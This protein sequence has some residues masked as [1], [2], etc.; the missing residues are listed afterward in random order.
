MESA[1]N[2]LEKKLAKLIQVVHQL[3]TENR[4]L[5]QEIVI[6]ADEGKR[7]ADK[8]EAARQRLQALID[9]MPENGK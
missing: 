6:K 9:R 1:L 8:I 4:T 3:R 7:L 5:R 2:E